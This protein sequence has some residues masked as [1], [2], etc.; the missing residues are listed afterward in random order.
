MVHILNAGSGKYPSGYS[1]ES[2]DSEE[3]EGSGTTKIPLHSVHWEELDDARLYS[4]MISPEIS[5]QILRHK[6]MPFKKVPDIPTTLIPTQPH[7]LLLPQVSLVRKPPKSTAPFRE[8]PRVSLHRRKPVLALIQM[9][10]NHSSFTIYNSEQPPLY[11]LDLKAVSAETENIIPQPPTDIILSVSSLDIQPILH[12]K[13]TTYE[14]VS[15]RSASPPPSF[16]RVW[17]Y[18]TAPESSISYVCN[19][20]TTA[21]ADGETKGKGKK[22]TSDCTISFPIESLYR[23]HQPLALSTLKRLFGFKSAPRGGTMLPVPTTMLEAIP[24]HS[25]QLVWSLTQAPIS[26]AEAA[27]MK[28]RMKRKASEITD[29]DGGEETDVEAARVTK[30]RR[31]SRVASRNSAV[32]RRDP[33]CDAMDVD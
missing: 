15:K 5:L 31:S 18:V 24:W 22:K 14:F 33:S 9:V 32:I 4:A 20:G 16:N 6:V 8:I 26:A 13:K 30:R 28:V 3:S 1:E 19:V 29:A 21:P 2:E 25:Q 12:Q 10:R 11:I 17:F 27:G 23:L 7:P